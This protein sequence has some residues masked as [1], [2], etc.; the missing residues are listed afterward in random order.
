[1]LTHARRQKMTQ[2]GLP[3]SLF[4]SLDNVTGRLREGMA[5]GS[6]S[7]VW[8]HGDQ[9]HVMV[10]GL[11]GDQPH[12]MVLGLHGNQYVTTNGTLVA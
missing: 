1:M 4:N 3:S 10:L 9:Q 6:G 12:V 7:S 8:L 11:H 2:L 5:N